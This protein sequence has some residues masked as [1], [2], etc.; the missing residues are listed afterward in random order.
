MKLT[1][2]IKKNKYVSKI[3]EVLANKWVKFSIASIIYVLWFVVWTGNLWLLPG[4]IIIYDLYIS[5][6][7]YRYVWSKNEK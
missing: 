3:R 4:I 6:Y 7:F 1:E 5:K 2:Q